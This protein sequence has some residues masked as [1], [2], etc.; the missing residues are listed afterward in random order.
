MD[1]HIER[2]LFKFD[3]L[4]CHAVLGIAIGSDESQTQQR[5]YEVARSL[6][7]DALL[8]RPASEREWGNRLFSKLVSPAYRTL[9]KSSNRTEHTLLLR[10]K[11][12]QAILE[13]EFTNFQSD[14]ARHLMETDNVDEV[15]PMLL[16]SLVVD[17]YAVMERALLR[18]GDLSE[19]NLAYLIRKESPGTV[20]RPLLTAPALSS[21]TASAGAG[22]I[23]TTEKKPDLPPKDTILAQYHRRAETLMGKKNYVGAIKELRDALRI[24]PNDSRGHTLLGQIYLEQNQLTMAK[25]HFNQALK[26]DPSNKIALTGKQTLEKH[27]QAT[28]GTAKGTTKGNPTAPPPPPEGNKTGSRG[29]LF[30]LFGGKK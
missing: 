16:D 27:S 8:G 13:Q 26:L 29:G 11:A 20:P 23:P 2:G 12:Q 15:Y 30:G 4:D 7:P 28:K 6:H 10:L 17:Q 3:F 9:S 18:I 25:I 24:E 19:L 5:Y 21:L 22:S 1:L 14:A